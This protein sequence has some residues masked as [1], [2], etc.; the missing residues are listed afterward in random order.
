M[1]TVER[2]LRAAPPPRGRLLER[3]AMSLLERALAGLE[4]GALEVR[5]PDGS[6]RHFGSGEPVSMEI[7]S[8]F[9]T[10][11]R[12]ESDTLALRGF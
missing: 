12:R 5:L 7:R 6:V 8:C 10:H 3:I 2:T 4:A 11:E 1:S 9:E